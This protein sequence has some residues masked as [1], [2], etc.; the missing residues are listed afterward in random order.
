MAPQYPVQMKE[1]CTEERIIL[2]E[3]LTFI[4]KNR[5]PTCTW[6]E[7]EIGHFAHVRN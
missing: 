1:N 4:L 2:D 6:L 7:R 5:E 3:Q